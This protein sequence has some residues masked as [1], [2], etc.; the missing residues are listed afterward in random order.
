MTNFGKLVPLF[1]VATLACAGAAAAAPGDLDTSFATDGV[2][3]TN[4]FDSN[5]SWGS[6]LGIQSDGRIVV[7]G[8]AVDGGKGAVGVARYNTDGSLDTSFDGD[9]KMVTTAHTPQAVAIQSDGRIVVAGTWFVARITA[10]GMPDA[11]F[12]GGDGVV[13]TSVRSDVKCGLAIQSDGKIIVAGSNNGGKFAVARYLADGSPDTGFA[14]S[15]MAETDVDPSQN[16]EAMAVALQGDGKIVVA[17]WSGGSASMALVRYKPDGSL[18]GTFSGDGIVQTAGV[19]AGWSVA[20]QGN[21]KI[22]VGGG[23]NV[24]ALSRYNSNGS[25]DATFDGDGKVTTDVA[26]STE[27]GRSVAVQ[28]DGKIVLAGPRGTTGGFALARYS[29]NG[30]L[31]STFDSDGV[32]VTADGTG[33]AYAMAIQSDQRLVVV[34]SWQD[35]ASAFGVVRYNGDG[36]LDSSFDGDG[37]A[38][39]S[40]GTSADEARALAVQSDGK[41]VV[42]GA[43]DTG[44]GYAPAI[45]RYTRDGVLDDTFGSGGIVT[46]ATSG[47][48]ELVGSVA[49][50]PD[51]K[52]L[53]VSL[54]HTGSNWWD[55]DLVVRRYD[56]NGASD[57]SFGTGGMVVTSGVGS[58]I[59][60]AVQAN[61]KIAAAATKGYS[62]T[63]L[64]Y[65]S[66]GTPDASFGTGGMVTTGALEYLIGMVVQ[67]DGKFILVGHSAQKLAVARYD[68]DGNLDAGFGTGGVTVVPPP[69]GWDYSY[70]ISAALQADGRLVVAGSAYPAAGAAS[71]LVV[72]LAPDGT[73]DSGFGAGGEVTIDFGG[74]FFDTN[75]VAIQ[76]DGKIVVLGLTYG[77]NSGVILARLDGDGGL[78]P[79]LGG[80]GVAA[81]PDL[82]GETI[83]PAALAIQADGRLVVASSNWGRRGEDLVVARLS[84]ADCAGFALLETSCL[85]AGKSGLKIQQSASPDEDRWTWKW[86]GGD[87]LEQSELG[88]PDVDR[89]Y[90]LCLYDSIGGDERLR[91]W[92]EVPP[93]LPWTSK[94]PKGWLY[95]DK[96]AA[97]AGVQKL[98]IKTGASGKSKSM[99][100]AKGAN[101]PALTPADDAR[102]FAQ[103]PAVAAQLVSSTGLCL[104]SEFTTVKKNTTAIFQAKVP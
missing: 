12:G 62:G 1:F 46:A 39:T 77:Y 55:G 76:D 91:A 96:T 104:G 33:V 28:A 31:D 90:T 68:A 14:G 38:V 30:S 5:V 92:L 26:G 51:G 79:R 87:A 52:I 89:Y 83:F 103:D 64:R 66:D 42:A 10:D 17:G 85:Q 53:G 27:Y 101:L 67:S 57:P 34:G 41:I 24:F 44:E 94:D 7:A 58:P 40:V 93:G 2:A 48:W 61:G 36:S 8:V 13:S 9:G 6:A 71:A 25:L 15:G 81:L 84:V 49:I 86:A 32:V 100:K 98:Q 29:S 59:G 23:A 11:T 65:L 102:L 20:I 69:T 95:S 47:A 78:D 60:V 82:L 4:L 63:L 73:L 56:G 21:G 18:D 3:L 70:G 50:Q 54:S 88:A 16:D 22:V 75:S 35:G 19:G 97:A 74:T 45:M 37:I 43:T 80:D 99:I 72:R